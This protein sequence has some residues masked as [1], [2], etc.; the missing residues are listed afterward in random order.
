MPAGK[1]YLAKLR[2]RGWNLCRPNSEPGQETS[3]EHGE[4]TEKLLLA[5]HD[6]LRFPG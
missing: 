1:R 5:L 6:Q 3:P 4:V 2:S